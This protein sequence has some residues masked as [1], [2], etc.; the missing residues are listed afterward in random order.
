MPRFN[1]QARSRSGQKVSGVMLADNE[2]QLA[3]TL[4]EMDL[5]L[6]GAKPEKQSRPIFSR[7]PVKRRELI[8][9]TVH[10]AA[11]IGAGIPMLQSFEDLSEQTS[12]PKM[13]ATIRVITEDLRGGS[14]LSDAMARH[15]AIFSDIF[16][17]MIKAGETSGNLV[18]VLEHL[19]TFLEWQDNLASEI[20]RATIYPATVFAAVVGLVGIL[21]GFVFPRIL[22]VIISLKVPLPLITRIVMVFADLVRNGWYLILLGAVGLFFL[23]RMLKA[24]DQGIMFVDAVKLRIPVVGGLVEKICLSRFAHHLGILLRTGVDISQSLTITERVV[25]NAVIAQAVRETKEKVIQ[26]GFLWRSLQET[27]V[28]PPLVVRM[29][30]VGETTGTIDNTLQRITEFYDREIPATVKRVFAVLEPLLI[31]MLAGM[32][33]MVALSI[34]VPL[35][36][37]LGQVGRK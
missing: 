24:S 21:I 18:N 13:A 16:I 1:Y 35:Y 20:R 25:G 31:C 19:T 4:R 27:G 28:F 30:F 5:Y 17:S 26:G 7:S 11:A 32:V 14:S 6:V 15:P 8:N 29:V 12:N 9:F 2:G 36:T 23:L 34:F 33:L 22:P 10:L 3:L 37:A